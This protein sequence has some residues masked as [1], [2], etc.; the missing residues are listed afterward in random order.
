MSP[1]LYC[2]GQTFVLGVGAK[3][4]VLYQVKVV[5]TRPLVNFGVF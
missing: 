4:S 3:G 1:F 2:F 5:L